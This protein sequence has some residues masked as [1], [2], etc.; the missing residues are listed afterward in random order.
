MTGIAI[1]LGL[2]A[3]GGLG[4]VGQIIT[5]TL[6]PAMSALVDGQSVEDVTNWS[7][8]TDTANFASSAGT[9]V[10]A[11]AAFTGDAVDAVTALDAGQTAG[12]TVTVTDSA[13]NIRV[14]VAGPITVA[15]IVPAQ[16]GGAQWS[17]ANTGDGGTVAVT[18]SGLPDDGGASITAIQ[19]SIDGGPWLASGLT[20]TGAFEVSG[21]TDGVAIDVAIR[22]VNS[23][24]AGTASATKS[25]TPSET[26]G[27]AT[28][29]SVSAGTLSSALIPFVILATDVAD[30]D[31]FYW[32]LTRAA[33]VPA[34]DATGQAQVV[35]GQNGSGAAAVAAGSAAWPSPP[36]A[37]LPSGIPYQSDYVLT[38]VID[39]GVAY[40]NVASSDE[41]EADTVAPGA[42]S[43]SFTDNAANGI[44][45]AFT[46]SKNVNYRVSYWADGTD[47]N[48]AAI[49]S[50]TGAIGT[51]TGTATAS[52][53]RT[54]SFL[55]TGAGTFQP[56]VYL[57]DGFGN[58]AYITGADVTVA[59]A[60]YSYTDT[61]VASG[62]V[63]D[64]TNGASLFSNP[65]YTPYGSNFGAALNVDTA[66]GSVALVLGSSANRF[67]SVPGAGN[68]GNHAIEI[69]IKTAPGDGQFGYDW[70]ICPRYINPTN[71]VGLRLY[72]GRLRQMR[73]ATGGAPVA[74]GTDPNVVLVNGDV[75]R[76]ELDGEN[77]VVKR[78][79]A[80]VITGTRATIDDGSFATAKPGMMIA[81]GGAGATNI[82]SLDTLHFEDLN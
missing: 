81:A 29:T 32:V 39:N 7:A 34:N 5:A 13:A 49:A 56:T 2:D 53:A 78:N 67:F 17:V 68:S 80:T 52:V 62:G 14:F 4:V 47:P 15:A 10:S 21:L 79:G 63:F 42:S 59:V 71:F 76:V 33:D 74:F 23:V 18:V 9:I 51:V 41:F 20:G 44:A 38:V 11:V 31:P 30:T 48:D 40:S 65:A 77:Y 60:L 82:F 70:Q 1:G 72:A 64:Y 25:V 66:D 8:F 69:T 46:A 58:K 73:E 35:A 36:N 43:V 28:I 12:F 61:L 6:N 3:P 75:I 50:G 22:A 26:S 37:T 19:F 24:G 55:A 45:W 54:G 27:G 57:E 16:F